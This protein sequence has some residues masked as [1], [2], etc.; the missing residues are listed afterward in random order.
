MNSMSHELTYCQ[1]TGFHPVSIPA[2]V[3]REQGLR[4]KSLLDHHV[5]DRHDVVRSDGLEGQSQDAIS[6]H[7]SQ[8]GRLCLA[9]SKHLVGHRDAAHL[10]TQ[11]SCQS[12]FNRPQSH[13]CWKSK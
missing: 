3:D 6:R 9:E 13:A 11:D 4:H 12:Q 5:K 10:D 2:Q 8:E 1:L 7:V